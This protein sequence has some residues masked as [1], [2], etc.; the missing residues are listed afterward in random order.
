MLPTPTPKEV[1][2]M[3]SAFVDFVAQIA[4]S[5]WLSW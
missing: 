1:I 3:L 4:A 2:A 5:G